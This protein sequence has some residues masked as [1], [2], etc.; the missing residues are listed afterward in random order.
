VTALTLSSGLLVAACGDDDSGGDA[1]AT[2]GDAPAGGSDGAGGTGEGGGG[3]GGGGA[4]SG[5]CSQEGTGTLDVTIEGLDSVDADVTVTAPDESTSAHTESSSSDVDAGAYALEA[6]RVTT[7]GDVVGKAYSPV[8]ATDSACVPDGGSGE[9][10]VTYELEPG[11]EKLWV[12][13]GGDAHTVA[14]DAADLA[15]SGDVTP[16]VQVTNDITSANALAFDPYGNLWVADS[17]E[18]L[19][20]ERDELGQASLTSPTLRITGDA[21]CEPDIL[22]CGAS[23]LAFDE[24]GDLWVSLRS[25]VNRLSAASLLTEGA[26]AAASS[27]KSPELDGPASLAFD[28][29]GNLWVGNSDGQILGFDEARLATGDDAPADHA[30]SGEAGPPVIIGLGAAESLA[31]DAD[32]N[33]WAAHFGPNVLARYTPADRE[34]DGTVTPEVQLGVGVLAL[35]YGI[36]FD[37][38]GNL[39]L[40]GK[41]GEIARIAKAEL[42]ADGDIE[43]GAIVL[44]STDFGSTKGLAFDPPGAGT[45]LAR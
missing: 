13:G 14:L 26:P 15:T 33:L 21:V 37:D 27:L 45:P 4:G 19:M 25:V 20:Y 1:P 40:T 38:G 22:P 11:S 35:L 32:G 8:S 34:T 10:S 39:W 16:T 9:L 36:A 30:F 12:L 5:T 28:A 18:L 2:G 42:T 24:N 31:F 29:D 3:A 7:S 23:S 43:N 17:D 44:A 41:T 6:R